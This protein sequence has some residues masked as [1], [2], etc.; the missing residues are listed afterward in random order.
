MQQQVSQ[1]PISEQQNIQ[2]QVPQQ[3][4]VQQQTQEQ[5]AKPKF[6]DTLQTEDFLGQTAL[7]ND[8]FAD[9]Q[10]L[11]IQ[12]TEAN[13]PVN[14]QV[15]ENTIQEARTGTLPGFENESQL[16]NNPFDMQM[17][18]S[19]EPTQPE[20]GTNP[21][22]V[23]QQNIEKTSYEVP[24]QNIERNP[25]EMP[26][27]KPEEESYEPP[28]YEP[29]DY[30]PADLNKFGSTQDTYSG[31]SNL[32]LNNNNRNEYESTI[33][34]ARLLTPDKKL[35]TCLGTSKNG[36]SFI[37]NNLAELTSSMGIKTAILDT[38]TNRNSYY[39]YTKNEENL[40]EVALNSFDS[41]INKQPEG[42]QVNKNLT[43]FTSL[44]DDEN[45]VE[46]VDEILET[47]INNYSLILVDAD[48]NTPIGYFKQ[49]QEL[50]LVQSLDILT[51]Q[52]LTAFLRKLKSKNALEESKIRIV[53]NKA[54]KVRGIQEK[55]IIGGMAYY[56]DP[57]MS[58]MTELFDR[59]TV[60][61]ITIPFED[62]T[63]IR[64]LE[65]II[66]CEITLKGY[67]K[68]FMQSLKE[69]ANMVYPLTGNGGS[70][71]RPPQLGNNNMNSTLNQM[72][73]N[74]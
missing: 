35:V 74:Y 14:P 41:L 19:Y 47:L 61:Y 20:V 5:P 4:S 29:S 42:I 69:L 30:K 55:T 2:Q 50:Y 71:Y 38:T 37:V 49:T 8:P 57:A 63:Y 24:Q 48:F 28:S 56:T 31:L 39:I 22:E 15:P 43:V 17:Q 52:P 67:S 11:N 21:Y 16:E 44:P 51:I 33:D 34:L 72:R 59:N 68:A 18:N 13:T 45:K 66:N 65:N 6:E 36:T 53:L 10:P 70:V 58:Y 46:R 60:K 23:S 64:Y 25:Y 27:E 62:E 73:R 40:R 3:Q 54:V 9:I 26:D 12:N 7:Y 1:Q 32:G